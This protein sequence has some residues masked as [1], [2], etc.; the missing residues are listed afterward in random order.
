MKLVMTRNET[1]AVDVIL[2]VTIRV[3]VLSSMSL[4]GWRPGLGPGDY[5]DGKNARGSTFPLGED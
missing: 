2:L 1:L 5:S 3:V 4:A